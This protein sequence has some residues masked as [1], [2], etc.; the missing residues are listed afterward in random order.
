MTEIS[1]WGKKISL[2]H[3]NYNE[4]DIVL[5][6]F[7]KKVVMNEEEILFVGLPSTDELAYEIHLT[8]E[9]TF[10]L[11]EG[12]LEKLQGIHRGD[13]LIVEKISLEDVFIDYKDTEPLN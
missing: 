4:K 12:L 7:N 10:K 5:S 11:I 2:A 1:N 6:F 3:N 13:G 9:E 8:T